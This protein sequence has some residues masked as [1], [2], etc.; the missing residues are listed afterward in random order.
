MAPVTQM[1]P[2]SAEPI[3]AKPCATNSQLERCRLPFIPSATTADSSDSIAPSSAKLTASGSTAIASSGVNAGRAGTGKVRGIPPKRVPSVST[4]RPNKAAASE[5]RH[6]AISMPGHDGR[7]RLSAAIAPIVTSEIATAA[8]LTVPAALP[9]ATSLGSRSPGSWPARLRP[10][11]SLS[12][13]ARMMTAIPA[14]KPTV[15]G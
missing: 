15:T 6:T 11:S 2:K 12:W 4:G 13:L 7:Q 1:P 3:L 9:S 14:V 5:A 8:R 10:N